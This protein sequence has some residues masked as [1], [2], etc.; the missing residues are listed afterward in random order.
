M[1]PFWLYALQLVLAPM[2]SVAKTADMMET[3]R[4]PWVYRR[5]NVKGW[6]V[7]WYQNGKRKAK[8]LPSKSLAEHF[9]HIKYT[10]LNSDVFTDVVD[11]NWDQMIEE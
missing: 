3:M 2:T 1:S 11:F 8:A 6:W 10:Q 5:K 7:G 4:K 9:R